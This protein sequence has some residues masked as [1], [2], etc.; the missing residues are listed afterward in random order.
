MCVVMLTQPP[1]HRKAPSVVTF[2][3]F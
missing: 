3:L 2:C 1:C